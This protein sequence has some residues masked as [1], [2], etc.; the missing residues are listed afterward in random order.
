M[1]I[2]FLKEQNIKMLWD[3]VSDE[4]IFRFLTPDNQSKIYQLFLNNIEGFSENEGTKTISLV[5]LNKK[6]ILLILNH[7]KKTYSPSKIKIHNEQQVEFLNEMNEYFENKDFDL[8]LK[9]ISNKLQKEWLKKYPLVEI[10]KTDMMY[11]KKYPNP[12]PL[13]SASA[14]ALGSASASALASAAASASAFTNAASNAASNALASA[15]DFANSSANAASNFANSSANAA[16][17]AL[18]SASANAL[19]SANAL[20][21]TASNALSNA[22]SSASDFASSSASAISNATPAVADVI[23]TI[24]N[25]ASTA[26]NSLDNLVSAGTDIAGNA[27]ASASKALASRGITKG[28][29]L[30][31]INI[32]DIHP[33]I[34]TDIDENNEEDEKPEENNKKTITI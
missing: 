10:N 33:S 5:N 28:G 30:E 19:S 1:S 9:E 23:S 16:S 7:I 18:S 8:D 11:Y 26:Y 13:G 34:L 25:T 20:T 32:E 14:S 2:N 12:N 6:Y 17:N 3:V 24:N 29:E 4:D 21:N 31:E 27:L 22:V 15:S